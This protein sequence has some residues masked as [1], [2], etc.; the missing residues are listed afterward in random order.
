MPRVRVKTSSFFVG[1]FSLNLLLPRLSG[2][3][4]RLQHC[5]RVKIGQLVA[6]QNRFQVGGAWRLCLFAVL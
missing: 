3:S 2:G 4:C 5:V 6:I 1:V